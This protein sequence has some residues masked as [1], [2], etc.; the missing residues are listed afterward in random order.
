MIRWSMSST[1]N[2]PLLPRNV[3]RYSMIRSVLTVCDRGN[4]G[5]EAAKADI[6]D[7]SARAL[8]RRVRDQSVDGPGRARRRRTRRQA[9]APPAR[10]A[11][12]PRA[13]RP[14]RAGGTRPARHGV[15]G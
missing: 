8:R 4:D 11:A 3:F 9:V 10:Y 15:R 1:R 13:H 14:R 7:V 2:E 6:L 5:T 12:G